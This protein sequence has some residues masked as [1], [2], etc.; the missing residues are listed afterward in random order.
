M[1]NGLKVSN[2][3]VPHGCPSDPIGMIHENVAYSPARKTTSD[4]KLPPRV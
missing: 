2:N 3:L 1:K 4:G